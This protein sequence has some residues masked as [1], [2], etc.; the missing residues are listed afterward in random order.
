M[1]EAVAAAADDDDDDDGDGGWLLMLE[2]TERHAVEACSVDY[3]VMVLLHRLACPTYDFAASSDEFRMLDSKVSA[4]GSYLRSVDVTIVG[5]DGD[6][7][8]VKEPDLFSCT[9]DEFASSTA[10]GILHT[11]SLSPRSSAAAVLRK[12]VF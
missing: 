8:A 9:A 12:P 6:V 11:S 4:V 1:C 10:G 7:A 2:D 3:P 5:A